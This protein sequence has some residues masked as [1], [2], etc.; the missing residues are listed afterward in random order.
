MRP[1]HSVCRNCRKRSPAGFVNEP[2]R[3]L[4]A[5]LIPRRRVAARL[6]RW[7][8]QGGAVRPQ[9]LTTSSRRSSP[10][11]W[12]ATIACSRTLGLAW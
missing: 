9:A 12:M 4:K 8:R 3:N 5:S 11:L 6:G 7:H 1:M 10:P 2:S